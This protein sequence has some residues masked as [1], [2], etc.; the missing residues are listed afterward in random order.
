[1]LYYNPLFS[2]KVRQIMNAFV[3]FMRDFSIYTIII[4]LFLAFL[5]IHFFT[6]IAKE[7]NGKFQALRFMNGHDPNQ[8]F[9]FAQHFRAAA[10]PR[11]LLDVYLP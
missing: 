7:A 3:T 6:E 11:L 2:K 5:E 8:V 1:M 10:V 9:T 4:R